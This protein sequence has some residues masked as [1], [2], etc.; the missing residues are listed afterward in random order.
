MLRTKIIDFDNPKEPTDVCWL[1]DRSIR[2][3]ERYFPVW[4][5]DFFVSGTN[6]VDPINVNYS[7]S[8]G[9]CLNS[10]YL[11]ISTIN[12][13]LFENKNVLSIA[14]GTRILRPIQK[15][16]NLF[17]EFRLKDKGTKRIKAIF[18]SIYSYSCKN[19]SGSVI[20]YQ[21]VNYRNDNTFSLWGFGYVEIWTK[22]IKKYGLHVR[23]IIYEDGE[24]LTVDERSNK[25]NN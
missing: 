24:E 3:H 15:N 4:T 6:Y 8:F 17:F 20:Y 7:Y 23:K 13:T 14:I 12:E 9:V 21:T 16:K 10:I 19:V 25:P 22:N 5:N 11:I 18:Y 2:L 1:E